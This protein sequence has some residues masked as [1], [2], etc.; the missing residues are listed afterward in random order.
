MI[1]QNNLKYCTQYEYSKLWYKKVQK[2]LK[3]KIDP[4]W[5]ND[6]EFKIKTTTAA[7]KE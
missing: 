6:F 3:L 7:K 1:L 5:R 4:I 2:Q